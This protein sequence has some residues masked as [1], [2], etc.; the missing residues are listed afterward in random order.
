MVLNSTSVFT[1]SQSLFFLA[2]Q[3]FSYIQS[4][5]LP[6]SFILSSPVIFVKFFS[7]E[8]VVNSFRIFIYEE[9]NDTDNM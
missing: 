4:F 9:K 5:F 2:S 1:L 7:K 3:V 6:G 8:I